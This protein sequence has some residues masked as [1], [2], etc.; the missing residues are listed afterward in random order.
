MIAG[1]TMLGLIGKYKH[2][3]S[4]HVLGGI[5]R[6][7]STQLVIF[8]GKLDWKKFQKL[9]RQFSIPFIEL[10]YPNHQRLHMDYIWMRYVMYKLFMVYQV[11]YGL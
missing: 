2:V 9:S 1:E 3:A 6:K 5:S 11:F 7:C 8:E 10:N 4:V